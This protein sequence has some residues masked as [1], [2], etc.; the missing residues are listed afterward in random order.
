MSG[1]Y[2]GVGCIIEEDKTVDMIQEKPIITAPTSTTLWGLFRRF[3]QNISLT[4]V[5]VVVESILDLLFPLFIGFA[6]NGLLSQSY[7]GIGA[8][9]GLGVLAL[10]VGSGRRFYD[11]RAYASIYTTLSAEMVER[12]QRKESSI[13][14]V[15]ARASLLTEFVEFLENSM[16]AIV[17]S[18]IGLVGILVIIFNLNLPVFWASIALFGLM[19]AVY[20]VSGRHN[21]RYNKEYNDELENRVTALTTQDMGVIGTHF[22]TVMRWNIKLSDLENGQLY[23]DLAGDYWAAGLCAHCG[24]RRWGDQLW[25]RFFGTD[26]RLPVCGK[27]SLTARFSSNR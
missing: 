1:S 23:R 24:G 6:I 15:S 10:L 16:P 12:E 7:W 3:G 18:T 17:T 9:G 21:F 19:V 13:S 26:V 8:L 27:R 11:T 22:Q 25:P 2:V 14:A 20:L 5:L 4:L